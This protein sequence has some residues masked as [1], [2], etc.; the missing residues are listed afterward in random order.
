[1]LYLVQTVQKCQ[2]NI[3]EF[4]SYMVDNFELEGL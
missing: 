2:E 1:M 3:L 4:M